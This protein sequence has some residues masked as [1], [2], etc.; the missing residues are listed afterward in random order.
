MLYK[1]ILESSFLKLPSEVITTVF[2]HVFQNFVF[3]RARI[4]VNAQAQ[5]NVDHIA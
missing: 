2:D 4:I 3:R 5:S 1:T